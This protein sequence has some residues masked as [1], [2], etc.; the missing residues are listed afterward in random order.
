M[1]HL[2]LSE[3]RMHLYHHLLRKTAHFVA[4]FALG[5][6]MT[7]VTK[8]RKLF[9]KF[10]GVTALGAVFAALDEW[11]QSFVPGRGPGVGDVVLDTCGVAAGCLITLF[12][13]W[14]FLRVRRRKTEGE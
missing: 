5:W 14:L 3:E 6:S 8:R 4:Y 7:R 1:F 9:P 2:T 12:A 13:A 11:H 10:P